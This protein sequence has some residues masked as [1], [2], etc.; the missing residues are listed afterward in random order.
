MTG[1]SGR[2][3]VLRRHP[4]GYEKG[5]LDP[6]H[7]DQNSQEVSWKGERLRCSIY[8]LEITSSVE[9]GLL[10]SLLRQDG[11][12]RSVKQGRALIFT[13]A[14]EL[15]DQYLRSA[16][17]FVPN[18]VTRQSRPYAIGPIEASCGYHCGGAYKGVHGTLL[19]GI[20]SVNLRSEPAE[21]LIVSFLESRGVLLNYCIAVEHQPTAVDI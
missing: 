11:R 8:L 4:E 5:A 13:W 6:D 3:R 17:C 1:E 21:Q 15:S 20:G 7:Y 12:V 19:N 14:L 16:F 10:G 2:A 18:A 9:R